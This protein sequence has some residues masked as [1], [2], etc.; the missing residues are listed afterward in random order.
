MGMY[1][2]MDNAATTPVKKEVLDEMIPFF[3]EKYGNPS[4]VYS[5]ASQSKK[6]LED[7]REKIGNIIGAKQREIYFTGSGSEGDNWAIK[8]IAYG[9]KDKGKSYYNY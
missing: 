9:N 1:I 2:Y 5:L 6:I 3:T 8:G 7:S 4:S